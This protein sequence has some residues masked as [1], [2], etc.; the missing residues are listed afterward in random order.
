MEACTALSLATATGILT[1]LVEFER[2]AT[3]CDVCAAPLGDESFA[4]CRNPEPSGGGA[5]GDGNNTKIHEQHS[6]CAECVD[7][8]AYIGEAAACVV[9][10]KELGGRRSA[11]KNAGVALRPAV[12]NGL[13]NRMLKGLHDAEESID[14]ARD[15]MDVD[16]IQEGADRRAAAVE[17]VR[18][19]RAEAEEMQRQAEEARR[20]AEEEKQRNERE[21]EEIEAERQR[22]REASLEDERRNREE[23]GRLEEERRRTEEAERVAKKARDDAV[24]KLEAA[25]KEARR[26]YEES[27]AARSAGGAVNKEPDAGT[28]RTRREMSETARAQYREKRQTGAKVKRDKLARHDALVEEN[29]VLHKKLRKVVEIGKDWV[30][31]LMG[32]QS[33]F[34]AEVETGLEEVVAEHADEK[35]AAGDALEMDNDNDDEDTEEE[36]D[37][38]QDAVTTTARATVG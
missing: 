20:L 27:R 24:R 4:I 16:R 19:K 30:D 2:D 26:I 10:L 5:R 14:K 17:E 28:S 34:D 31:R 36:F 8:L 18:R 37:P 23:Q 1:T 13:A 35:E 32:D 15:Q 3:K 6:A 9:C 7:S 25:K 33:L 21:K 38:Q 29:A 11:I 22:A 12:R